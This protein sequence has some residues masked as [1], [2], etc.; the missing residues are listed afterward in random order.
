MS[1]STT[2]SA[3]THAALVG[4]ASS[5]VVLVAAGLGMWMFAP[6]Q[7]QRQTPTANPS[8][9]PASKVSRR[10][11]FHGDADDGSDDEGAGQVTNDVAWLRSGNL[12]FNL[13]D[14]VLDTCV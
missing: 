3:T 7:G 8:A 9:T 14:W 4:A 5:A 6:Q 10:I 2:S 11:S 13:G 12:V 1:S